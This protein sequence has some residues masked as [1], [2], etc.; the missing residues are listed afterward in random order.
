VIRKALARVVAVIVAAVLT[1]AAL[2]A[3]VQGTV[4][5]ISLDRWPLRVLAV[6]ADIA[7]GIFLLVGCVWIATRMAVLILGVGNAEFPPL[8]EDSGD[9]GLP[10][11]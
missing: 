5:A 6:L 1:L 8:P 7:L 11:N 9:E 3:L 4:D 2:L 10:K